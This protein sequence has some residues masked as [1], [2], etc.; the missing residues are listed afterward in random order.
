MLVTVIA[1]IAGLGFTFIANVFF[2]TLWVGSALL[3]RRTEET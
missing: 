2:A 1:Q 3:F